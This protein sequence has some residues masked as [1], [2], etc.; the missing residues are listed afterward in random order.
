MDK[1]TLA[2]LDLIISTIHLLNAAAEGM[3]TL[4]H[5]PFSRQLRIMRIALTKN[6]DKVVKEG[7]Q[8]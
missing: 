4:G 1:V 6:L 2:K 3:D 8:P 7:G 5:K